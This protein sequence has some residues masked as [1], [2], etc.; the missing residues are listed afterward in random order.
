MEEE[1][2]ETPVES[3]ELREFLQSLPVKKYED[4]DL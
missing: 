2:E 1:P 3:K 4:D